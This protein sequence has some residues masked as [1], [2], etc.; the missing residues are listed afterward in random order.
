[1]RPWRGGLYLVIWTLVGVIF[2]GPFVIRYTAEGAEPPWGEVASHLVGWYLWGLLFPLIWWT[3][4]PFDR[5]RWPRW[6][7]G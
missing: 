5:A 7:V 6:P 1:M 4:E 3:R 2:V